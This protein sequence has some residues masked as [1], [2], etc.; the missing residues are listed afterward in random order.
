MSSVRSEE[1]SLSLA[2]Q[3]PYQFEDCTQ[4]MVVTAEKLCIAAENL[5]YQIVN[6]ILLFKSAVVSVER[7]HRSSLHTDIYWTDLMLF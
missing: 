2:H 7:K 3:A 4:L 6:A 5:L 1:D